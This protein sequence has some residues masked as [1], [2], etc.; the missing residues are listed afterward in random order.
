MNWL[1]IKINIDVNW[2]IFE[3]R[4]NQHSHITNIH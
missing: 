2:E 4:Q 1:I 3:L